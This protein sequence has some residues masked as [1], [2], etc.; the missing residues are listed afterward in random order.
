MTGMKKLSTFVC[1]FVVYVFSGERDERGSF[2]SPTDKFMSIDKNVNWNSARQQLYR[3]YDKTID[4]R[5]VW[6]ETSVANS[7]ASA[8]KMQW[9]RANKLK[10]TSV[11]NQVMANKRK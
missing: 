8:S 3:R 1:V 6:V 2:T 9:T 7:I 10:R 4:L 5:D 11:S